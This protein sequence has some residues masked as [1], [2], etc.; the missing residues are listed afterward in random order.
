MVLMFNPTATKRPIQKRVHWVDLLYLPET[1]S[2]APLYQDSSFAWALLRSPCA[3]SIAAS[4]ARCTG[5]FWIFE[6]FSRIESR[7]MRG[8]LVLLVTASGSG[9]RA[10][11]SISAVTKLP[12]G[13]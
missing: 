1:R 12:T 2:M 6:T 10:A 5:G 4:N 7:E 11:I 13:M 3:E 8:A 9:P